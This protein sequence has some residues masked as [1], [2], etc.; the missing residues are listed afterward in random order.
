MT[1]AALVLA[2]L[3]VS[4]ALPA[5]EEA[6]FTRAVP[7]VGA[8]R[9]EIGAIAMRIRMAVSI[10]GKVVQNTDEAKREA[11]EKR[12]TVV[13]AGADAVTSLKVAYAKADEQEKGEDGQFQTIPKIVQGR[14]YLL[15]KEGQALAVT[16][17]EGQAA[18]AEEAEFLKQ[19]Y[20]GL[21][22]APKLAAFLHGRKVAVGERLDL[23]GD[24]GREALHMKESDFKVTAFALTLKAVRQAGELKCAVFDAELALSLKD[25]AM[26]MT[27][28]PKGE[29]VV[30]VDQCWPV[31]TTLAGPIKVAG[32]QTE[33]GNV[34]TMDG[35]GSVEV[36]FSCQ[37]GQAE[38]APA[39]K[40]P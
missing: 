1:R 35:G 5:A 18:P 2:C 32:Q 38:A 37:Y 21:S 20:D 8:T 26:E 39:K 23:S 27:M 17:A 22:A 33:G 34:T 10:N 36:N 19:D 30:T 4:L 40:E 16:D 29:L 28:A 7:P 3:A 14:T 9:L 13:A 31:S 25:G 15:R 6:A 24:A 12:E 11:V